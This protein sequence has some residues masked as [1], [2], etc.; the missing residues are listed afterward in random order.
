MQQFSKNEP[1]VEVKNL[2]MGYEDFTII[3]DLSFSVGNGS[4]FIIMGPSGSG[5]STLLKHLI[6][7]MSPQTGQVFYHGV[8]FTNSHPDA[9][10]EILRKIGILYQSGALWS[11]LTLIENVATPLKEFTCFTPRDIEEIARL[12]LALVGLKGFED[13]YPAQL[14]GGM[15]KRGGLA[16]AM[17]LDPEF[18]FFDEPSAGLDPVSSR[19]LDDLILELRASLGT[20]VVIVTHELESIFAIGDEAIFLDP[21]SKRLLAQGNPI[22]LREKPPNAVVENFLTRGEGHEKTHSI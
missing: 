6:G 10:K 13:F 19:R 16:R 18:L 17:A 9:K 14:S 22:E 12:K 8:D 2:T 20:T 15:K 3:R 1:P 11:D 4:I 5:K 7:L 21:Q